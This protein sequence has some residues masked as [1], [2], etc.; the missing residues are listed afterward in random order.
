MKKSLAETNTQGMPVNIT[1]QPETHC[2]LP[3]L[4]YTVSE[5]AAMYKL[6]EKTIYRH[7]KAGRLRVCKNIRHLRIISKSL[8]ECFG[9]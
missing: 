4:A 1:G 9:H 6:S 3:R 5:V 2:G 7:V 8:G